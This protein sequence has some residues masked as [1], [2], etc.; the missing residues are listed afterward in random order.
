MRLVDLCTQTMHE[1]RM[2][3]SIACEVTCLL[4]CA[5]EKTSPLYILKAT[6]I[7]CATCLHTSAQN[8]L[9]GLHIM[10]NVCTLY[11]DI[12]VSLGQTWSVG[13][14]HFLIDHTSVVL[15]QS[16]PNYSAVVMYYA[17][18][19]LVANMYDTNSLRTQRGRTPLTIAKFKGHDHIV[20]LLHEPNRQR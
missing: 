13:W 6:W 16:H 2:K 7:V 9:G 1:A 17:E 4:H 11:T 19:N 18:G 3:I 10:H 12:S 20:R 15:T 14:T 5:W 8:F